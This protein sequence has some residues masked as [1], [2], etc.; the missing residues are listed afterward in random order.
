MHCV[1]SLLPA[2]PGTTVTCYADDVCIHSTTPR[3]LQRV[4]QEFYRSCTSCGLILSPEKSRIFSA[5]NLRDLPVFIMGGNIIPHCTQ[6]TYLGAPV[7]I[8]PAIPARQRI[9]P[10]VKNLLDRLEPRFTPIKWLA[11]RTTGISIPV[12][13]TLYILF[14]R[15]VVDYL[16]PALIQLPR[17]A[18]QTLEQF[19]NRVMGFILGCPP[20]TRIVNMQ[21]EL[22]LPPLIERIYA[23]VTLFSVKCLHFPQFT[24][25]F[26]AVLRA[27]L[28]EDA[29]RPQLR[30][31]GHN[32]VRAVCENL[33]HLD[34]GV[35][36]Q[37]VIQD[38]P[39]WRVPIP[40]VAFTPT[41]KDAHTSLQ[42]QLVLETIAKVSIS[43]PAG[44][45]I[46]V[47]G[48]VQADGSAA[49]AMFSPTLDSPEG[50]WHGRRLPNSS[51]STYCELQ[52][53]WDAVTLLV[54][55]N[56]NGLVICDS[57]L[58]SRH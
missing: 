52:G 11:S 55:R 28:D 22:M 51:S 6:Y 38:L 21:T 26:S 10:M 34:I 42:K 56:V 39:P 3:D 13:R 20:S 41:S 58:H 15:S 12:A 30:P 25:N 45:H 2:I 19:Q 7:R 31:G 43:V 33:R 24:P 35:P 5:R 9:H 46:Y 40:A 53:I 36:E 1:L 47:E 17:Q 4:L 54:R 37:A 14:L 49:C 23:N 44:H 50:G 8:T 57:N 27:S 16:S 48:S 18:L 32:L 29:P